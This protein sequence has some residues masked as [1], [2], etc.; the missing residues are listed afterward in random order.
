MNGAAMAQD[1]QLVDVVTGAGLVLPARPAPR[2]ARQEKAGH[3][4][5]K[6]AKRRLQMARA[7]RRRNR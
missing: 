5:A 7:S 2:A 1:A 3:A 4:K 6:R